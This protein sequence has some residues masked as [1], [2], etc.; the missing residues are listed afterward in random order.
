MKFL[1]LTS[2]RKLYDNIFHI[3][4]SIIYNYEVVSSLRTDTNFFGILPVSPPILF[5]CTPLCRVSWSGRAKLLLHP[6]SRQTYGR[7][8]V[9]VRS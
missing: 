9:C 2:I 5:K 6:G 8:P 7:A 4:I 3:H 1:G